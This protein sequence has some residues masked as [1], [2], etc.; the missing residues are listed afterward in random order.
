MVI[1]KVML[2]IIRVVNGGVGIMV[3]VGMRMSVVNLM[4]FN[5]V[6]MKIRVV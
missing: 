5:S 1:L 4:V 2:V 3:N 6:L